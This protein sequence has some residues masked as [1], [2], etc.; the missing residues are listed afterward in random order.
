MLPAQS[1]AKTI[2]SIIDCSKLCPPP[3]RGVKY[4]PPA[5]IASEPHVTLDSEQKVTSES[6]AVRLNH[7]MVSRER[8]QWRGGWLGT[9]GGAHIYFPL[10]ERQESRYSVALSTL[11]SS[12]HTARGRF[13]SI[14]ANQDRSQLLKT[15]FGLIDAYNS[16]NMDN[17]MSLRAPNCT[18]KIYPLRLK[19]PALNNERYRKYFE[20]FLSQFENYRIDV[21]DYTEDPKQHKVA[22]HLKASG[23]TP[24]GDYNNEFAVYLKMTDDDRQIVEVKE[25]VDSGFSV[26][27]FTKLTARM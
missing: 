11:F 25:F 18:Q 13:E 26:P 1:P 22:F 5:P 23:K 19:R 6:N 14:M 24:V 17:I 16:W 7:E 4:Q 20:P 12:S 27:F 3:C 9:E 2:P 21:L 15:A 10:S 8:C